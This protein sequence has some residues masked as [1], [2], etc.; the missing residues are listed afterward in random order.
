MREQLKIAIAIAAD[1]DPYPL[2]LIY[3][4][5]VKEFGYLKASTMVQRYG[6]EVFV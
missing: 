4:E 5:L 6:L 3:Q 2:L 1:G